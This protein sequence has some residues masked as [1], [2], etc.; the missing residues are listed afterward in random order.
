MWSRMIHEWGIMLMWGVVISL[1][2]VGIVIPP[3]C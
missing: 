1:I 3:H 2:V